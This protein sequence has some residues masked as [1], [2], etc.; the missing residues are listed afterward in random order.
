MQNKAFYPREVCHFSQK[1]V[2]FYFQTGVTYVKFVTFV[3]NSLLLKVIHV[4]FVTQSTWSLSLFHVKFVT[5]PTWSL[6]PNP[7]TPI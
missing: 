1:C 5:F 6:S 4:K 2:L 7:I 3:D